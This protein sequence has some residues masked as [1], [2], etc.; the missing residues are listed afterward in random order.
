MDPDRVLPAQPA[1]CRRRERPTPPLTSTRWLATSRSP[2][3]LPLVTRRIPPA[4]LRSGG[5]AAWETSDSAATGPDSGRIPD[6]HRRVRPTAITTRPRAGR[7]RPTCLPRLPRP[8]PRPEPSRWVSGSSIAATAPPSL[9]ARRD[10]GRASRS[11]AVTAFAETGS[12]RS[13]HPRSCRDCPCAPQAAHD[14]RTAISVP[15]PATCPPGF[16]S[17]IHDASCRRHRPADPRERIK[18][19]DRRSFQ[20]LALVLDPD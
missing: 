10:S 15:W 6:D 13:R 9:S 20:A 14:C 1:R 4:E 19:V 2:P 16:P 8:A 11:S 17:L 5:V 7:S 3:P 12:A 18:I